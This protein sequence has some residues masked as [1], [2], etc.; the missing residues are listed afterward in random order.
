MSGLH[1]VPIYR[2]TDQWQSWYAEHGEAMRTNDR[3]N[4]IANAGPHDGWLWLAL[5]KPHPSEPFQSW[6]RNWKLQW[7]MDGHDHLYVGRPA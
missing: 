4:K 5:G 1:P 7:F 2:T 6:Y 3:L